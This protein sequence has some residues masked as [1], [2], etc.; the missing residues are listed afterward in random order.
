MGKKSR[1][2]HIVLRIKP[3]V[4]IKQDELDVIEEHNRV[5]DKTDSVGVGKFG[6]SWDQARCDEFTTAIASGVIKYLFL[7]SKTA[8]GYLGFRAKISEVFLAKNGHGRIFAFPDYYNQLHRQPGLFDSV[9][10][11]K[12]SMWFILAERLNPHSLKNLRLCSN[13]R[14]ILESLKDSRAAT[15][16]VQD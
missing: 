13:G 14:P 5:F 15:M 3:K 11:T 9:L 7:V 6:A 4:R 2:P 10:A 12:P 8:T 16:L 1:G